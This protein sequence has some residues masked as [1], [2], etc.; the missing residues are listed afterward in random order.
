MDRLPLGMEKISAGFHHN[1]LVA[2][3]DKVEAKRVRSH[4]K[5]DIASHLRVP[6]RRWNAAESRPPA[7]GAR[8]VICCGIGVT[9][10][11]STSV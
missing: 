9:V 10:E 3:T 1:D 4:A 2:R 7:R 5:A 6:Q 8:E 11:Y